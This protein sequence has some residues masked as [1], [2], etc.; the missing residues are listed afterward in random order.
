MALTTA[1]R[2]RVG[3][4]ILVGT[5]AL[6]SKAAIGQMPIGSVSTLDASVS[7]Q[8]SIANDRAQLGSNGTVVAKEH[9]AFVQL[10]RGGS[11]RVCATS[12]VHFTT[13]TPAAASS[14]GAES[15]TGASAATTSASE[16]TKD[17]RLSGVAVT[18]TSATDSP[19]LST[20]QNETAPS[21]VT[22]LSEFSASFDG[23]AQ[24]GS[25]GDA[26]GRGRRRPG[27]DSGPTLELYG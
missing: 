1:R 10:L 3:A 9:G 26:H 2:R 13:G 21:G 16:P 18:D 23:G 24:S 15:T 7:G 5:L 20:G 8:T 6:A 12:G 11:V 22:C 17:P 27:H 4:A 14:S 19:A 25:D